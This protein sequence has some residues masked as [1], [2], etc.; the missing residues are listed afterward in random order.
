MG[1]PGSEGGPI[2]LVNPLPTLL[3][4]YQSTLADLL[5]ASSICSVTAP[6][7]GIEMAGASQARRGSQGVRAVRA[8]RREL[9]RSGG[10]IICI[11]PT[12]GLA[13]PLAWRQR[14]ASPVRIVYHDPVPM[15][16]QYG[17]GRLAARLGRHGLDASNVE[18]IV[19]SSLAAEAVLDRG[20]PEPL[21]T[22]HPLSRPQPR[23]VPPDG[24][25][26]VV[27]QY[28]PVRD[29]DL[30]ARVGG[31]LRERGLRPVIVG[32]DWPEVPGW[33][34]RSEFVSEQELT[35]AIARSSAV[36]IPYTRYYQSGIAIRAAEVSVPV[37]GRDHPFLRDLLDPGWPG[38]V[39]NGSTESWLE[40]V[41]DALDVSPLDAVTRY[42]RQAVDDWQAV[43]GR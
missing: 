32:R 18:V 37:V 14:E 4:R 11:W 29:L 16:R 10:A 24:T 28:K 42:H 6:F 20:W 27:G 33:Q 31:G 9:T 35:D 43:A 21:F 5:T 38:L 41:D 12:F 19:H 13:D 26:A 39:A 1:D 3:G 34:V 23:A 25:V 22:R 36:L 17:S 7:P 2:R 30:M 15:R 40:A 8:V